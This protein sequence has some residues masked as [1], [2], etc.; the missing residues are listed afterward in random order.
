MNS[1]SAYRIV[2][3]KAANYMRDHPDEFQMFMEEDVD[4]ETYCDKV[5]GS[6]GRSSRVIFMMM[7][8]TM[9]FFDSSR[10]GWSVGA[11]SIVYGLPKANSCVQCRNSRGCY[12]RGYYCRI[13]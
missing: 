7:I 1:S 12:G 2:R 13:D 9:M 6:N 5:E 10:M 4:Y 8:M 11:Q 3:R